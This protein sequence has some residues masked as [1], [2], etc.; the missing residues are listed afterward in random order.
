MIPAAVHFLG[1]WRMCDGY[2]SDVSTAANLCK[3]QRRL[4][5][6][7]TRYERVDAEPGQKFH[8]LAKKKVVLSVKL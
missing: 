1:D 2:R 4:Y 8:T 7:P 3:A 6:V 5:S